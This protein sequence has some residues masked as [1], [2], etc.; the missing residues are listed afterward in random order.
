MS[1]NNTTATPKR[2][3]SNRLNATTTQIRLV[4]ASGGLQ[5]ADS[6]VRDW[7]LQANA[8][9]DGEWWR[10][11]TSAFLHV[12]LIHLAFKM[13]MLWW[14]G[15]ALEAA[16]GRGRFVG[17][18]LVSAL[19]GSAGALLLSPES[20]TLGASGAVFGILGAGLVLERRQIYV[21]GGGALIVI[22]LNLAFTFL[23]PGNISVGGHLGGL[24]GGMLAVLGLSAARRHPVYGRIDPLTV[25]SLL[26][27]APASGLVA[28][29][30]VR[31]YA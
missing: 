31:G 4:P 17:V 16:L 19:A 13:L 9:A 30:R 28:Y 5:P 3:V 23:G 15:Q 20:F 12:N 1:G 11:L 6:F 29:F 22:L 8:V 26:G 27:L 24:I 7:A 2:T 21:F 14:F 25:P 10:L 18:Y